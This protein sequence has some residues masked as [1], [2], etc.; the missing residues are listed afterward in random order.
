M[1]DVLEAKSFTIE[2]E[3][4]KVTFRVVDNRCRDAECRNSEHRRPAPVRDRYF[5][6]LMACH[7]C[8]RQHVAIV[9]WGHCF[10]EGLGW[11]CPECGNR[12]ALANQ[13]S[14][15]GLIGRFEEPAAGS[16]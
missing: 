5:A 12:D 6:L 1:I 11:E 10:Q 14:A 7:V 13:G 8:G 2:R 15:S 3:G 16:A 4:A 9:T